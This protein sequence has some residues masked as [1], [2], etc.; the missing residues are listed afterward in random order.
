VKFKD[1]REFITFLEGKGE[2]LRIKTLVSSDLEITEIVDRVVKRGGPA[3]LFE[4]VE[5]YDMPV[6]VNIYGSSSAYCL[7]TGS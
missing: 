4:N 1:V 7:G 3:L 6:L 5:G 2:L